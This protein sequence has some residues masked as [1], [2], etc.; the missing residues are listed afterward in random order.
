M[1]MQILQNYVMHVCKA[2]WLFGF[3][4]G[5]FHKNYHQ[6]LKGCM[7]IFVVLLIQYLDHFVIFWS[8][9]SSKQSHVSLLTSQ[10]MIFSNII[11]MLIYFWVHYLDYPIK[12]LYMDN[13]KEFASK[14]F[15]D[16][17]TATRIELTYC[18]L[19]EHAQNG[20]AES[21]IKHM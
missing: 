5:N 6:C 11:S 17:C 14:S 13:A 7:V 3:Q 10:N 21:F 4:F 15:E 12:M 19:Y 9:A 16:C 20:L 2:R 1:Q 18:I 8:F